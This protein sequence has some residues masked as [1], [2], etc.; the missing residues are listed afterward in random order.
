MGA[1]NLCLRSSISYSLQDMSRLQIILVM[2]RVQNVPVRLTLKMPK[3][4][5]PA[6]RKTLLVPQPATSRNTAHQCCGMTSVLH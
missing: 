3:N 1:S 6:L 2:E 5:N 4:A